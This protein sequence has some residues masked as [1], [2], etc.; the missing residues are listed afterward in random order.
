MK[1]KINQKKVLRLKPGEA[2]T[3]YTEADEKQ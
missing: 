2:K 3:E 1:W